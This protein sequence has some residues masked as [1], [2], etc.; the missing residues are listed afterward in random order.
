MVSELWG[1]LALETQAIRRW[2]S[3]PDALARGLALLAAVSI[4]VGA[5][6]AAAWTSGHLAGSPRT[7]REEA[8]IALEQVLSRSPLSPDLQSEL[9]R[10]LTGWLDLEVQLEALPRPLGL[11]GSGVLQGL[12]RALAAPYEQLS[13]WLIYSL[14]VFALARSLGGRATLP[15]ML[16]A[17]SL[18]VL[19][20]LLDLLAGLP[21]LGPLLALGA[22]VWGAAIY[23]K[24]IA[25]ANDLDAGRALVAALLPGLVALTLALLLLSLLLWLVR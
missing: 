25:V 1:A 3:R 20:H 13:A 9:V 16:A 11:Q 2:Q 22:G 23:I 24:A 8:V 19:P 10:N 15:E 21:G 12:G 4:L 17:S 5:G 14:S 7:S 6:Q 18:Y